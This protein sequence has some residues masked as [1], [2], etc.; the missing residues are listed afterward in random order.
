MTAPATGSAAPPGAGSSLPAA[1]SAATRTPL[2]PSR[3]YFVD[4]TYDAIRAVVFRLIR[5]RQIR[6]DSSVGPVYFVLYNVESEQRTRDL[7][8]ALYGDLDPLTRA[9]PETS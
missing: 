6:A 5:S 4:S 9:V 8:A 2:S 7:A 1:W 3:G